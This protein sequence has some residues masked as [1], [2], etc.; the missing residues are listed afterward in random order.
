MFSSFSQERA[1]HTLAQWERFQGGIE[2][3]GVRPLILESWK[4]CRESGTPEFM[5]QPEVLPSAEL[6]ASEPRKRSS[7]TWPRPFSKGSTRA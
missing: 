2:P 4:R 7:S 6:E 3:E 1:A 5:S